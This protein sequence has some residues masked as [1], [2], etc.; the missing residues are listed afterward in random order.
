MDSLDRRRFR[1]LNRDYLRAFLRTIFYFAL[2]RGNIDIFGTD[3]MPM[4]A[5]TIWRARSAEPSSDTAPGANPLRK[6][7]T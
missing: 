5:A 7:V 3:R 2:F 1:E 6:K 4:I